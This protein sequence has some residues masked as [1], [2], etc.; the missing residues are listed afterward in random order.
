[1]TNR[2]LLAIALCAVVFVVGWLA[3]SWLGSRG[4]TVRC[5]DPDA[6]VTVYHARE[7]NK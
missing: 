5:A 4:I 2:Q 3:L 1:M 7:V 6:G